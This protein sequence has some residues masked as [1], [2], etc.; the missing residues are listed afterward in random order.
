MAGVGGSGHCPNS[1]IILMDML[2]MASFAL[3][4][5]VSLITATRVRAR[6][7][8]RGGALV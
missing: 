7:H 3:R 1:Q 8:S 5:P 2:T 4:N 6:G